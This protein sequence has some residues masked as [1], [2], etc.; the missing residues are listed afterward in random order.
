M[1]R[2]LKPLISLLALAA[3]AYLVL[4]F[5]VP[6]HTV[7]HPYFDGAGFEVIAHGAGQGLQPKNTLAAAMMANQLNAN[8]IEI[9]IHA[10]SDGVLVMSHD[11]TVDDMTN[12]TGLI[13]EKTFTELQ[14]LDAATGFRRDEG[15]PLEGTGIGIPALS[16]VFTAL[17]EARYIIEIKQLVPSIAQNLCDL[18]RARHMSERVLVGSFYTEPLVEFRAACPEV[19]TSMSQ[20]EVTK[21]VV[22]QKLR[23]SHLYD[24]PGVALQVPVASGRIQIIT[25]SFVSDMQAR[26]LKVHVWTINSMDEMRELIE[27]GVD[28]IITDYPDRLNALLQGHTD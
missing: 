21:L 10:S 12:G 2:I 4:R 15:S 22:L 24:V 3:V 17:P 20:E 5:S 7:N 16:D 13:R 19:A 14:A 26:G 25:E 27:L 28:G 1:T 9:D 11:D 23:L 18:V 8:I 6:A